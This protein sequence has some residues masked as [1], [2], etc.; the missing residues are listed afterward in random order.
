[1]KS[2]LSLVSGGKN[3]CS[4]RISCQFLCFLGFVYFFFSDLKV[5]GHLPPPP[6]STTDK[7]VFCKAAFLITDWLSNGGRNCCNCGMIFFFFF[8]FPAF[9][10]TGICSFIFLVWGVGKHWPNCPTPLDPPLIM[11]YFWVQV[12]KIE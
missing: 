7:G 9:V 4:C 2:W 6:G 10:L 12:K 5:G 3:C 11:K 8:F 1:M